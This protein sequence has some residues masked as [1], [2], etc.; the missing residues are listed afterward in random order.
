M[1]VGDFFF[2]ISFNSNWN[3]PGK[4]GLWIPPHDEY[5][6]LLWNNHWKLSEI[7]SIFLSLFWNF[8]IFNQL[9]DGVFSFFQSSFQNNVNYFNPILPFVFFPSRNSILHPVPAKLSR[10]L[11]Q[12]VL[13]RQSQSKRLIGNKIRFKFKNFRI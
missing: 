13:H 1:Y 7:Y 8:W 9:S 5:C 2:R 11:P 3:L 4:I 6:I 10:N 12:H